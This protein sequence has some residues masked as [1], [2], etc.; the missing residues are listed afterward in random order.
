MCHVL[1]IE[2]EA[3]IALDLE[4]LLEGEGASSFAFA[5][6]QDEAENAARSRRP[7]FITADVSLVEGT[8]P[9]AVEAIRKVLG[10]IP[11]IYISATAEDCCKEDRLTR[12]LPKPL[13]RPAVT[14]AFR[15]LL[16]LTSCEGGLPHK[17]G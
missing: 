15:E 17:Q 12:V 8:G 5:V 9:A 4:W 3:L 6:S 16:Q 13:N 2:D 7:D 10:D 11:V 14:S 1:I